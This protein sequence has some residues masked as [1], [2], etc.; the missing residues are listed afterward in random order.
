MARPKGNKE[1]DVGPET[2]RTD[3]VQLCS[4][5]MWN[6]TPCEREARR[7]CSQVL[8]VAFKTR[9]SLPYSVP[10]ETER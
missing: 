10:R 2:A 7:S 1:L 4:V 9:I 6:A 5:G 3:D 8:L